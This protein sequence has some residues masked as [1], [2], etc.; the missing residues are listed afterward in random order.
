[1][2]SNGM[3]RSRAS[4]NIALNRFTLPQTLADAAKA[5]GREDWLDG[6]PDT[7]AAFERAWSLTVGPAFQPG[8]H[9]AYVAPALT[10]GGEDRVLKIMWRHPE[11]DHEPDALR[12]WA[13]N[14]AVTVYE[15]A[16]SE[17]T[18]VMLLERCSPGSPLSS[19]PE[20]N[21]DVVIAALLRRLWVE[22]PARARFRPL[23]DMCERW[24][25]QATAELA[26]GRIPLDPTIAH[27]GIDL[28]RTLP[29]LVDRR[30]VLCTDLHAGNVLA[31]QR[32]S[33]LVIDPKPYVGDPAYDVIQHLLNCG[34]RLHNDPRALVDRVAGLLDLDRDRMQ[35]W[36]FSRCVQESAGWPELAHVAR[37]LAPALD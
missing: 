15:V 37:R 23:S 13:G 33:W 29:G 1:M 21:Q 36:L 12:A 9:T 35:R 31:A 17:E 3:A 26:A 24:A 7:V 20:E 25:G 16:E 22:P 27:K 34:R 5:E 19:E 30:V 11:A 18:I 32:E 4:D 14:G 10:T 28:L 2:E 6:L 8:G